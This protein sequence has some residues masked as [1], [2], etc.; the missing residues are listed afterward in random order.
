MFISTLE[1]KGGISQ[2]L[3]VPEK[4]VGH[5]LWTEQCGSGSFLWPFFPRQ[6]SYQGAKTSQHIIGHLIEE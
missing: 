6:I 5:N 2:R 3:I 1:K 4:D